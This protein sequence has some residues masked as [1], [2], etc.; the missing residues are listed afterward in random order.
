MES[1]ITSKGQVT[2]PKQVREFLKLEVGD[3]VDF[4]VAADGSV[5]LVPVT[6]PVASLKGMLPKPQRAV[7]LDEMEA[8]IAHGANR[9]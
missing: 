4:H 1:T 8:A 7:T 2:I 6:R 9:R 3:R 5:K